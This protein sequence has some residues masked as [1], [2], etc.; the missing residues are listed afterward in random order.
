MTTKKDGRPTKAEIDAWKKEHKVIHELETEDG[1]VA[2]LR[3]PKMFDL[4][5]ALMADKK[6][7][8]KPLD[9]NRTIAKNCLLWSSPGFLDDEDR[10]LELYTF[11]GELAAAG[12][13]RTRKL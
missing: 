8:S 1:G 12:E 5:R 13:S 10:E 9:F 2:I 4:E 7:G 3:R 6:K 11:A